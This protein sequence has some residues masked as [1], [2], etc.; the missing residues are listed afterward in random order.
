MGDRLMTG[1]VVRLRMFGGVELSGPDGRPVTVVLTQPRRL[2]LLLYLVA[3]T[4]RGF[5]RKDTV[6]AIFWPDAD[7]LRARQALNRA[8]YVLRQALDPGVLATRGDDEVGVS[9]ER[10]WCDVTLFERALDRDELESALELYRGDLAPGFLVSGLPDFERWLEAERMRLRDRAVEAALRL[11]QREEADGRLELAERWAHRAGVVSPYHERA[12]GRR[13]HLLDRLGDRA[14]ALRAFEELR[15]YLREDLDVDP[16]PETLALVQT[17]RSRSGPEPPAAQHGPKSAPGPE[18]ARGPSGASPP[19]LEATTAPVPR[20]VVHHAGPPR[21][22][23]VGTLAVALAAAL[24]ALLVRPRPLAL[25]TTNAV[26]VTSGPGVEFQPALSPDGSL[27][28]FTTVSGGHTVIATRS[29]AGAPGGGE[30]RLTAEPDEFQ[31]LPAWSQDGELLRYVRAADPLSNPSAFPH[32]EV[33]RLGGA[34]HAVELPRNSRWAAWS[35]DD[36]RAAFTVGDSIFIYAAADHETRLLAVHEG[37]WSPNSL[38]WSPD[39]RWIAYVNGNPVWPGGWNTA[40]SG[41]WLVATGSG[42]RVRL[43]DETHLNVSPAWLDARHLLYISDREGQRE[44]YL[45]ELGSNGAPGVAV[46][47]SGGT[48]AHSISLSADGRRLAMAKFTGR[49]NVWSFPLSSTSPLLPSEGR[50][51]TTGTQVVETHDVSADGRW[52]VYDSNLRGDADIYRMRL[53]GGPP[54]PLVTDPMMAGFPRWSPDGHEVAFYAGPGT[55]APGTDIW[56]VPSEGGTPTRLTGDPGSE[57][58]PIWSPD[59]LHLVFRSG[60]SGRPEAWILSRERVAGPWGKARQLTDFG[61]AFQVW[62][63]DGSGLFC[64]NPGDT[65]LTLVSPSGMVVS[66]RM[67]AGFDPDKLAPLATSPDGATLFLRATREGRTGI[68][69][70]PLA[71]GAPHLALSLEQ[72]FLLVQSYPGTVNV[73]RDRLYLTVGEFESDI[74]VMDLVWR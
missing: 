21:P 53:D 20:A 11:A 1:G 64:G 65:H 68:W 48:D 29:A 54:L 32:R 15:R 49:Q 19:Q 7:G 25:T 50:P 27:V 52:L 30:V 26:H 58:N 35:R 33:N 70:L 17:V 46:K 9:E 13:I 41:I 28:A 51:V 42:V 36:T 66:R 67:L 40:A 5:H 44:I 63:R 60:Q 59:G 47:V 34:A 69:A 43:T 6:R 62:A 22:L 3:A 31:S 56:V 39:G 12:A 38:T 61:C 10:L 16:S 24:S 4:P 37:G 73:T 55:D 14:G 74:W 18:S 57:E 2:A 71:G 45:V 23:L 8:I 72:P